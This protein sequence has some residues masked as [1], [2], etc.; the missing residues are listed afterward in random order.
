MFEA[1]SFAAPLTAG[2]MYSGRG[3]A[4]QFFLQWRAKVGQFCCWGG[5]EISLIAMDSL[6]DHA[7]F[8]AFNERTWY[9][10]ETFNSSVFNRIITRGRET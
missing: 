6:Y 2:I 1:F 8:N 10:N 5:G 4:G 3:Q 7:T 9:E